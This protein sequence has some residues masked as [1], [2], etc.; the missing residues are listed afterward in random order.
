MCFSFRKITAPDIDQLFAVRSGVHENPFSIEALAEQGITVKSVTKSLGRSHDGYLCES[1][2]R[3]VGFAMADLK[4]GE[5]WVIA[6]LPE[7]E[8]RGIG[9]QLLRL[10]EELLW[11]AGHAS[12]WLWTGADRGTRAFRLYVSSGWV[13]SELKDHQLFMTK[14]RPNQ[15]LEPT[16]GE[17]VSEA[18]YTIKPLHL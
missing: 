15:S 7:Y 16:S 1:A 13:E 11:S 5:V 4:A 10:T 9:R 18:D 14:K 3:V 17:K 6:V 8:R 12:I 2:G